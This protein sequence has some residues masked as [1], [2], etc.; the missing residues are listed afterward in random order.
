M[1]L[2]QLARSRSAQKSQQ[3]SN[4]LHSRTNIEQPDECDANCN[5]DAWEPNA[6]VNEEHQTL[7]DTMATLLNIREI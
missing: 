4:L 5:N 1:H 6:T 7:S 2:A 3:I